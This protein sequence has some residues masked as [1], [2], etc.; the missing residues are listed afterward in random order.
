[1]RTHATIALV[2]LL[3]CKDDPSKD[4]NSRTGDRLQLLT[5]EM[6]DGSRLV[7]GFWDG[8]TKE[9]CAVATHADGSLRCLPSLAYKLGPYFATDKCF[10]DLIAATPKELGPHSQ[11]MIAT[12]GVRSRVFRVGSTTAAG[13]QGTPEN[14]VKLDVGD[15]QTAYVQGAEVPSEQFVEAF[16][17]RNP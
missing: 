7:R 6:A 17:Q 15:D 10:G 5:Y 3:A 16:E 11:F 9:D 8:Q 1:M 12:D 13:Y 14:C 4:Q 2:L